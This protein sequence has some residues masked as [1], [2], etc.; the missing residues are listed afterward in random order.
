[1]KLTDTSNSF[2]GLFGYIRNATI[3]NLGITDSSVTAGM[4]AAVLAGNIEGSTISRCYTTGNVTGSFDVGGLVGGTNPTST[5]SDCYSTATV[6]GSSYI[7]GLIGHI[8]G[9]LTLRRNYASGKV[10]G[11]SGVGGL[12]GTTGSATITACYYDGDTTGYYAASGW[13]A[14]GTPL[15]TS[16]MK[17]RL[18]YLPG[19]ADDWDFTTIWDISSSVN[20]GYPYLR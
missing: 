17:E 10:T 2:Q 5:I 3:K 18:T 16:T 8:S 20:S 15:H 1:M 7:G 19:T 13:T 4:Y 9:T 14:G 12:I 6:S 11:S